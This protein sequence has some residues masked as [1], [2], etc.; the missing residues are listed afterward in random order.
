MQS[1]SQKAAAPRSVSA[2]N[3]WRRC[4][5]LRGSAPWLAPK[6]RLRRHGDAN[7]WCCCSFF[8][9]LATTRARPLWSPKMEQTVW[10]EKKRRR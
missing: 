2:S 8:F 9:S 7:R 5:A 6:T 10:K 1:A 4:V 3:V